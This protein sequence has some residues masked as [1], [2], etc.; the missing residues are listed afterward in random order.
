MIKGA[1]VDI[2]SSTAW[3]QRWQALAF[4]RL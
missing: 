3:F 2:R 4:Q 1:P